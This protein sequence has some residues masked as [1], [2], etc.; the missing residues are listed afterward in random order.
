M[1]SIGKAAAMAGLFAMC[2]A[3][4]TSASDARLS[5]KTLEANQAALDV[6]LA[7]PA[8]PP[9]N[10]P[11][12]E[13]TEPAADEEAVIEQ[14]ADLRRQG[15]DFTTYRHQ[16]TALLHAIRIGLNRTAV[17]LLQHGAPPLQQVADGADAVTLA[18][19]FQRWPVFDALR[20][21]PGLASR[22][23]ASQA[24]RNY[25][26]AYRLYAGE[27]G[28]DRRAISALLAR[29]IPWPQGE[30]ARC[31]M[32]LALERQML[33]FA[34]ALPADRPLTAGAAETDTNAA[35]AWRSICAPGTVYGEALPLAS[36]P[37]D[38]LGRLD[39]K[40]A[41]PLFPWLLASVKTPEDVE[42]LF[43]LPIRLPSDAATVA[44]AMERLEQAKTMPASLRAAIVA[45]LPSAYTAAYRPSRDTGPD[46]NTVASWLADHAKLPPDAF[47]S[48]LKTLNPARWHAKAGQMLG[49]FKAGRPDAA[50]WSV[51]FKSLPHGTGA[52][53][54][55]YLLNDVPVAAW[56]DLFAAGY[57]PGEHEA[58]G[59]VRYAKPEDIERGFPLLTA[60]WPALRH[61]ALLA[62]TQPWAS[63]CDEG[64]GLEPGDVARIQALLHA[65]AAIEAAPVLHRECARQS[66]PDVVQALLI[67]GAMK[68]PTAISA[69]SFVRLPNDCRLDPSA[70]LFDALRGQA[71]GP[72][73]AAA[74]PS[75]PER[76]Q[77]I[78]IPGQ[79]SCGVMASSGFSLSRMWIH[80]EDFY[81]GMESHNPCA[82]GTPSAA[83]WSVVPEGLAR[84][85]LANGLVNDVIAVRDTTDGTRYI[86]VLPVP[87][88]CTARDAPARLLA[89]KLVTGQQPALE[90]VP[91][92]ADVLDAF[93][94][95]CGSKE[96][97]LC[98]D[99]AG[100]AAIGA[101]SPQRML[102]QVFAARR[103]A[104]LDAVM[105][106]DKPALSEADRQG[107]AAHWLLAA[108]ARVTAADLPLADKRARIAWLLRD[109]QRTRA[110]V[111]NI[112][113]GDPDAQSVDGL[114]DWLPDE[115]WPTLLAAYEGMGDALGEL[116]RDAKEKKRS[117]LACTIALRLGH[118]CDDAP[119]P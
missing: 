20:R 61:D 25:Y 87:Q 56:P 21:Q 92:D 22:L 86:A 37:V 93:I 40:L 85:A 106:L 74:E 107:V 70:A 109:H 68:P 53:E 100:D 91:G 41:S 47:A 31:F 73:G 77:A 23:G 84:T 7:M 62:L 75:Q 102:D 66:K 83:L 44:A 116:Q 11:W 50:H 8:S 90:D 94:Q 59:W 46:E 33:D 49:Y 35:S 29:R 98:A 82:D 17:W 80:D 34:L 52:S 101:V 95:Q 65:G 111:Q 96:S 64:R 39:R 89:W 110:A 2:A 16:G 81:D 13:T 19:R 38:E 71:P 27:S 43:A 1:R 10:E 76:V 30:D 104:W 78:A 69:H 15:A 88:G 42:R 28:D 58:E 60:R 45:R 105:R 57:Q 51:L 6:V 26:D 119:A 18:I 97:P 118:A 67:T 12:P 36:L 4:G 55:K 54:L 79:S 117:Y 114:L 112:G 113:Y 103:Q 63:R 14:L 5:R 115:D 108:F 99:T 72:D 3:A 24:T 9:Y 32:R 48:A